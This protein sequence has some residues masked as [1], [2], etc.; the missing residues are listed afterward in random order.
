MILALV[1]ALGVA[2]EPLSAGADLVAWRA[3]DPNQA[4]APAAYVEFLKE[5]L[6]SP[7][8]EVAL[9]RLED[10]GEDAEVWSE[11]QLL[12]QL[13]QVERSRAVHARLLSRTTTAVAIAPLTPTGAPLASPPPLVN[14]LLLMGASWTPTDPTGS[15]GAAVQWAPVSLRA[16]FAG[17]VRWAGSLALAAR[18]V[19]LGP[20]VEARFD[21]QGRA[22]ASGG[23]TLPIVRDVV[24]EASGGWQLARSGSRPILAI[25]LVQRLRLS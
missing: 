23:V 9:A 24:V 2:A 14:G 17:R 3:I 1:A 19:G 4:D 8:A 12:Q 18:S 10:A 13:E 21:T 15:L 5:W 11:P 16:R 6:H 20:L 22:T 7:L 25:E